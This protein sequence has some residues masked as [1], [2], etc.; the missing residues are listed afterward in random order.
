MFP[1][2]GFLILYHE[3]HCGYIYVWHACACMQ[4]RSFAEQIKECMINTYL[5][6]DFSVTG[7]PSLLVATVG[8][9]LE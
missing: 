9:V 4:M 5:N 7:C 2:S 1:L 8:E 6:A 3:N